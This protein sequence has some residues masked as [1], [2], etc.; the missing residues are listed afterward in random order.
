MFSGKACCFAG[1]KFMVVVVIVITFQPTCYSAPSSCGKI[2][3]ISYPFRLKG[4]GLEVG[5]H[6]K[7][8]ALT[9]LCWLFVKL[10]MNVASSFW[11]EDENIK[12]KIKIKI[13]IIVLYTDIYYALVYG[14]EVSWLDFRCH[15]YCGK[16]SLCR[17]NDSSGE[18]QD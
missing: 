2:H 3:S 8:V 15:F 1:R 7:S 14:F 6:M 16:E 18:L 17:L 11:R 13:N 10:D 4:E 9:S 5:W 12:I